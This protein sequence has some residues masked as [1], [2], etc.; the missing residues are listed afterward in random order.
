MSKQFLDGFAAFGDREGPA[1]RADVFFSRVDLQ[2]VAE[3]AEEIGNRDRA[4]VDQCA[5]VGCG[6]DDLPAS[7]AST[8]QRDVERQR[9]MIATSVGIDAR[10][11]TEFAHPDHQSLLQQ[12]TFFQIGDQRGECRIDT[13]GHSLH[14][15]EVVLMR[16]PAGRLDLDERDSLF[17]QPS[18]QQAALAEVRTAVPVAG[19]V[20]FLGEI[21]RLQPRAQD[22]PLCIA[23][24]NLVVADMGLAI[25]FGEVGLQILQQVVPPRETIGRD[26]GRQFDVVRRFRGIKNGERSD[27]RAQEARTDDAGAMTNG[28][29]VRQV[30]TVGTKLGGGNGTETRVF[31]RLRLNVSGVQLVHGPVVVAFLVVGQRP[32]QRDVLHLCREVVPALGDTDA[33]DSRVDRLRRAAVVR[34][35]LWIERLKLTWSSAHKQQD[36]GH[37]TLALFCRLRSESVFPVQR[38]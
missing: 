9:V 14:A 26:A 20:F 5:I 31:H 23:E 22:H 16:V 35:R 19:A 34:A 32:N 37:T 2:C 17:D 6:A 8:G 33:A 27:R 30:K 25:C 36:A 15:V 21:K 13:A 7:N 18:S 3:G 38:G 28:D 29:E 4:F 12:A 11:A 10:C 1:Q 24:E